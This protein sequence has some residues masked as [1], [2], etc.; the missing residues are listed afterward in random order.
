[1]AYVKN[2]DYENMMSRVFGK[3]ETQR[4]DASILNDVVMKLKNKYDRGQSALD[5]KVR[6]LFNRVVKLERA[7]P[8]GPNSGG[9]RRTRGKKRGRSKRK[10]RRRKR[11]R[12]RRKK[13][14]KSRRRRR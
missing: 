13:R 6:K 11:T 7:I 4:E 1:M 5:D 14:R 9:G 10:S 12:K 3:L 8:G 2:G